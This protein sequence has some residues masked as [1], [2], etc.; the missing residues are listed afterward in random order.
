MYS[1]SSGKYPPETAAGSEKRS[2]AYESGRIQP[3][4]AIK[5][6]VS[7]IIPFVRCA[8]ECCLFCDFKG[9]AIPPSYSEWMA[10][11]EKIM[12]SDLIRQDLRK[13]AYFNMPLLTTPELELTALLP[14]KTV[15]HLR[16]E[17]KQLRGFIAASGM[18]RREYL[19]LPKEMERQF[20]LG[21][22][23]NG[24]IID[25]RADF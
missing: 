15:D 2:S 3:N 17:A 21:N 7:L 19:N 5:M 16:L 23:T 11:V 24:D 9:R 22:Y 10:I 6:L 1:F 12:S 14:M 20:L 13:M 18:T 25:E 8:D 4:I